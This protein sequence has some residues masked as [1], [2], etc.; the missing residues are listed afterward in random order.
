[1][2]GLTRALRS[3]EITTSTVGIGQD[4]DRELLESIATWGEGRFYYTDDIRTV[5]QI[6]VA[7]TMIV[8][9]PIRVD[10]AFTPVW[11]HH[12]EFWQSA[13]PLP[14]LGGYIITTPKAAAAVHLR[15]PDD[16]PILAT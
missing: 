14:T 2:E 10:E 4:A 6:F 1:F 7:E 3:A 5:P 13:E 16:S 9:R 12:A 15:A 11:G 8:S